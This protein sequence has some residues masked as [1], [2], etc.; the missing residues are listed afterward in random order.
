MA[1]TDSTFTI[2]DVLAWARTKPADEAY[3]YNDIHGCAFF[4]FLKE[5]GISVSSAGGG[6]YWM[7]ENY[8]EQQ[9]DIPFEALADEPHTFGDLADR[10]DAHVAEQVPA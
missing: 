3:P 10:L 8:D 6:G 1:Q 4:Q 7:D 9:A 5:R 2:A